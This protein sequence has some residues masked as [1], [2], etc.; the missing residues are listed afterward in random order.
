[1][2]VYDARKYAVHDT[3]LFYWDG[4]SITTTVSLVSDTIDLQATD[5]KFLTKPACVMFE[6]SADF[7]LASS[8]GDICFPPWILLQDAADGST[9]RSIAAI[10]LKVTDLGVAGA[11]T[12]S[13]SFVNGLQIG[14]VSIRRYSRLVLPRISATSPSATI[15]AWLRLGLNA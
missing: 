10:P 7:S 8:V 11:S 14:V 4:I 1:M 13:S 15:K 3:D 12:I 2:A 9:F 6:I 5:L